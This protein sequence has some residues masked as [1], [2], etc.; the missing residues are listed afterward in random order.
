MDD[1]IPRKG[2]EGNRWFNERPDGDA[3]SAWFAEAVTMPE[4]LKAEDY[5]GGVTLIP[6][7]E[8]ANE[9]RGFKE[10]GSPVWT[11]IENLVF[12]PY[13]KV[14]TRVQFW[15]DLLTANPD[16]LGVVEAIDP[17]DQDPALPPGF[18]KLRVASSDN[19]ITPYMLCTMKVTVFERGSVEWK[20]WRNTKT[21]VLER[22]RVG[23]TVID[24]APATKQVPVLGRYGPDD[25]AVMKAQTGAVGRA[26]GMAG[27]LIVPGTGVATAEDM[28]E[29]AA[30]EGIAPAAKEERP[31]AAEGR[32]AL[33]AAAEPTHDELV[34]TAS[35]LI[36]RLQA[37]KPASHTAFMAWVQERGFTGKVSEM[38]DPNIKQLVKQVEK[39]LEAK[40]GS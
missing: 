38:K 30:Q 20:E 28:R 4:G 2:R 19:K 33:D 32:A 37:E 24:A 22:A 7:K 17:L 6:G 34:A 25:N 16:W 10:D 11:E 27:M 26:L 3:V 15:T 31:P 40:D 18:S 29:L 39:Y 5:V 9:P 13:V 1:L 12:T 23:K 21:G 14:E 35:G 36:T 8:K